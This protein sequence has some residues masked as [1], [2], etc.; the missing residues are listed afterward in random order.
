MPEIR[1]GGLPN[2]ADIQLGSI[3]I[4]EVRLGDELGVEE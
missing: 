4:E 3:Q 2:M 1:L